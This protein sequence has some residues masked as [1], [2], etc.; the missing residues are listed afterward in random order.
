VELVIE[1][2][3][4]EELMVKLSRYQLDVVLTN[5]KPE[6]TVSLK[7]RTIAKQPISIVGKPLRSKDKFNFQTDLAKYKLLLPSN[8]S[9]MRASFDE[10]CEQNGIEYHAMAEINDMPALRLF[11]R[12]AKCIAL[13]PKVVVQDEINNQILQEYCQLHGLYEYFYAIYTKRCLSPG[14]LQD[15]LER[16]DEEIL[17]YVSN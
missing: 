6:T 7:F 11:L 5:Q 13:L 2:G 4:Q 12:D 9:E 3:N 8:G 10:L 16:T 1:S 17:N 15:L 14:L